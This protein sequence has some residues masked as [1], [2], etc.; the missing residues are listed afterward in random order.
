MKEHAPYGYTSDRY[1]TLSKIRKLSKRTARIGK[2]AAATT[3]AFSIAIGAQKNPND[4]IGYLAIPIAT[5]LAAYAERKKTTNTI[6]STLSAYAAI[7]QVYNSR[8]N[9]EHPEY[10]QINIAPF[11]TLSIDQSNSIKSG[12]EH[13]SL[14]AAGALIGADIAGKVP[15]QALSEERIMSATMLIVA[16]TVLFSENH[17]NRMRTSEDYMNLVDKTLDHQDHMVQG[18]GFEPA[19][20]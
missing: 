16:A 19:K 13:T 5:S 11:N 9:Y 15:E 10:R 3:A 8:K 17:K 18:A 6:A 1:D 12:L 7:Q 20:A 4:D 2:L 14:F